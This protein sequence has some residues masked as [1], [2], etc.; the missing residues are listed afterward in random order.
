MGKYHTK[1]PV[2]GYWDP[3]DGGFA[4][5]C[6]YPAAKVFKIHNLSDVEATLV[7]YAA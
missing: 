3:I 1:S 5:Y 4:E 6:A 2:L 7:C